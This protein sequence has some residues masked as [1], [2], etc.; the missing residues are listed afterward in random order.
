MTTKTAKK[1]I[2]YRCK[3]CGVYVRLIGNET[4]REIVKKERQK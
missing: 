2:H 4:D 3:K 1:E